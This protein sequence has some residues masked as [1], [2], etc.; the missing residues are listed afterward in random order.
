MNTAKKQKVL[1]TGGSGLIGKELIRCLL[2]E[3][4]EVL[5]L[6]RNPKPDADPAQYSWDIGNKKIDPALPHA[7]DYVI[8]LAG[9][10]IGDKRWSAGRK[11]E[12]IS[13]RVDAVKLL[14]GFFREAG[15][16]PKAFV[17]ASATGYYGSGYSERIF[18]ETD[19][20]GSDFTAE[21]CAQWEEAAG[22]FASMG[23]RTV[24]F[25]TG[26]VLSGEGGALK[27][28]MLTSPAGFVVQTGAGKNYMPWIHIS[29]LCRMYLFALKNE[30]LSGAFNAVAPQH[31]S[32]AVLM[33]LLAEVTGKI[34]VKMPSFVI[35]ALFG[36]M[37]EIILGGSRVASEKIKKTGFPFEYEGAADALRDI[38]QKKARYQ[39]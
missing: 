14:F 19:H 9:S 28:L 11:K 33:K 17:T 1:I 30:S 37:S 34:V 35:R 2:R 7:I 38:F 22:S 32:L 36:E 12:I 26:I 10:G 39:P 3:Q 21:V 16:F 23:V 5:V 25:R 20:K 8:H 18:I 4:Y 15:S 27:K 29:D 13:S 31:I 24:S 6:T